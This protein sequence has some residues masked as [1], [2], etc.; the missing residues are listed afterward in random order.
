MILVFVV[1]FTTWYPKGWDRKAEV[2]EV[3][4]TNAVLGEPGRRWQ[5]G[6]NKF[7]LFTSTTERKSWP[8]L[9]KHDVQSRARL[10]YYRP[11]NF[12]CGPLDKL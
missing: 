8:L 1:L 3:V 12:S 2:Q 7:S 10:L 6:T 9:P 11:L 5:I 4:A